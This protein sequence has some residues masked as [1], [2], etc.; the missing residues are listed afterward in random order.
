MPQGCSSVPPL[1]QS[2]RIFWSDSWNLPP[3]RVMPARTRRL[4]CRG[5]SGVPEHALTYDTRPASRLESRRGTVLASP[6]HEDS[7]TCRTIRK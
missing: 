6:P 7:L 3:A 1:L 5:A 2:S 4:V